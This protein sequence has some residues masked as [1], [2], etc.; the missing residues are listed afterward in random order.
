MRMNLRTSALAPVL[1]A[2]IAGGAA[3]AAY[4]LR[5]DSSVFP[6]FAESALRFAVAAAVLT[7]LACGVFGVYGRRPH[8]QWPLQVFGA[9]VAAAAASAL[10]MWVTFGFEGVS[11]FAF[12]ASALLFVLGAGAWRALEGLRLRASAPAAADTL[13]DDRATSPLSISEGLAGLV[14]YRELIRNLVLKDL[15]LKYRGSALGFLWSLANPIVMLVVYWLAFNYIIGI[16]RAN[17]VYFLFIGMLAWGFFSSAV[18]MATNA[19]VEGGGLLKSVRFPRAVLPLAAV[20]FN[21]AQYLLTFAVL[22][23]IMLIV[24]GVAPAWPMTAFP[25]ILALLVLFTTGVSM[26]VA[27]ATAYFRDVKHLVEVGLGVLFWLTPVIYD[28]GDVPAPLRLPI[29]LAPLSPFVTALHQVFYHQAWPDVA[30]W[31]AAVAWSV[32]VFIGGLTLFLTFEDRFAEQ[33]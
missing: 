28:L 6:M 7:P 24:F 8:R 16:R 33:V 5:F 25:L 23:P 14:L 30:I 1:D 20:L 9:A 13:F 22:L 32:A 26:S 10:T 15:K 21:L 3:I 18:S 19:I 17:F 31:V 12:V 11:R 27:A 4:R 29:L 2:A